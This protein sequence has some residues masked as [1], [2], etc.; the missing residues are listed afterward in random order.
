MLTKVVIIGLAAAGAVLAQLTPAQREIEGWTAGV[1]KAPQDAGLHSK[2]AMAYARRARETADPQFYA[3]AMESV[4]FALD[5]DPDNYEALR[6][7]AWTLLGQHEFARA[8]KLAELLNH[9]AP[10]DVLIYGFLTDAYVELGRYDKAV[11][12]AQW[13]LDI[14]PGN[15]AALTRAAYLRELY[16][17]MDGAVEL[18]QQ[19]SDRTPVTES[20]DLAWIQ[21]HLA[22][23]KRLQGDFVG[24]EGHI[25]RA[26]QLFPDYHYALGERGRL[27]AAQ[28]RYEEAATS[29]EARYK[30]APHPENLFDWA[31]ALKMSG[32]DARADQMFARFEQAAAKESDSW[33]NA[34]RELVAY[35]VDYADRPM[36]ALK[37][38]ARDF[39]RRQDV[40][41]RAT[42]AW[43]LFHAGQGSEGRSQ[44]KQ[45]LELGVVDPRID[46]YAK[47]MDVGR[48][49]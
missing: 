44:M 31:E 2:L 19:A 9:R 1:R 24:A 17:F 25:D 42:Y 48:S 15:V 32:D 33:D 36:D 16:G 20:E 35:Y 12:A 41:T 45:V 26:L 13:M 4:G 46:R 23:L 3:K 5:I 10:D 34:N 29:F 30:L 27:R 49:K 37:I 47:T 40:F 38:A 7:K 11:D 6:A 22:H 28:G 21:V 39:D 18:L 43:A 8:A 14:R